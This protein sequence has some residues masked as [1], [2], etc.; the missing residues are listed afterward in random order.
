M[1]SISKSSRVC[2][3]DINDKSVL[4]SFIKGLIRIN[5]YE[6]FQTKINKTFD[7]EENEVEEVCELELIKSTEQIIVTENFDSFCLAY[8]EFTKSLSLQKY[9][10]WKRIEDLSSVRL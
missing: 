3:D 1:R 4:K 10:K 8:S 5:N 2:V 6:E 9:K 7:F